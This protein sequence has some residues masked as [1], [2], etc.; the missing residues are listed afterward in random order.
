MAMMPLLLRALGRPPALSH[1]ILDR[2][3]RAFMRLWAAASPLQIRRMEASLAVV[4]E[5]GRWPVLSLA[6]SADRLVPIEHVEAFMAT[7][8]ARARAIRWEDSAHVR[9][10]IEHRQAYFDAVRALVEQVLGEP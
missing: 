5:T 1:P 10:M 8:G 9:H 4:R 6:S 2:P 7:L 3:L